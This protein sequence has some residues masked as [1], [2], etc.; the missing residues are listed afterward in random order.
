MKIEPKANCPLDNFNPCRQLECAWFLKIRGSNPN[1]GEELDDWGCSIAW[2]PILMI[3]NSQQQRSTGAAV[4]SFRNEMVKS[5]EV[6]QKV[7]LAAAGVPQT[8]QHMILENK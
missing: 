1:T 4:E 5:N 3:E 2:M 8:A 7:L 6:G